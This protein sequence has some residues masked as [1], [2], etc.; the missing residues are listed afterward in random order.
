[1]PLFKRREGEVVSDYR[2][3]MLMPTLYKVYAAVLA[4]RIRKIVEEERLIPHNQTG[5]RKRM[6]ALDNIFVLNYVINRQFHKEKG[7]KL[8]ALF[9]NLILNC[10]TCILHHNCYTGSF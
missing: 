3:V 1:M 7:G 8:K 6:R 2:G 4:E 10:H 5:F 9:V